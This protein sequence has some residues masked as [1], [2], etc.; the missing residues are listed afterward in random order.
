MLVSAW[1]LGEAVHR[2]GQPALVGQLL[3]GVLVGPSVLN[4]IQPGSSADLVTVENLALFLIMLLT[5]LAVRPA[6]I[7]AAGLHG[8]IVSSIAFLIPFSFGVEAARLF[9]IG[10][11]SSFTI[12]LTIS[13]TAVPVNAIILME[14]GL[15]DTD[16]GATVIAAGVIDDVISFIALGMIQQYSLGESTLGNTTVELALLKIGIFLGALLVCERLIRTHS[17]L[18]RRL[19]ESLGRQIRTE[20]SSIAV[21]LIFAIFV[22]LLAE[23]SGLQLVIGA[24]FGGFLASEFVGVEK[25]EKAVDVIRGTTFGFFGPFAFAFIGGEFVL[26]SITR[27]PLLVVTLLVVAVASK[28]AGGYIGGWMSGFSHQERTTIGFLMNSRGFV[29]L[30][31]AT[32]AYQLGLI[33]L[34]LFSLVVAVGIITTVLSP[35]ATRIVMR[36]TTDAKGPTKTTF[37]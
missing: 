32:T 15:L 24:F 13:I 7:I 3:G 28:L 29:E 19:T 8:A 37:S 11:V 23:W 16:L 9:G 14:L 34:R 25:L 33:D 17:A 1:I 5:G 10:L 30:V 18:T 35:I 20:G 21:I 12:G 26:S 22:S 2:V 31:I 36:R 6:R 4:V 27:I